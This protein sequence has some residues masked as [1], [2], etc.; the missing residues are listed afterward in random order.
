MDY[1]I[2]SERPIQPILPCTR[3]IAAFCQPLGAVIGRADA[4][5]FDMGQR[6]AGFFIA[7]GGLQRM[8]V[9][10]YVMEYKERLIYRQV[11]KG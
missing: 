7:S 10:M 1:I 9:S 8:A 5:G 11:P 2:L 4:V 3:H 6:S